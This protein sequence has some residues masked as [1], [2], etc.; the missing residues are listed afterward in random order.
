MS[1]I[2]PK[3]TKSETLAFELTQELIEALGGYTSIRFTPLSASSV[4]LSDN[5]ARALL[6]YLREAR[7]SREA[8]ETVVKPVLRKWA[9]EITVDLRMQSTRSSD[10][11]DLW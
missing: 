6:R 7:E 5:N 2:P 1:K 4:Q 9:E 8:L 10:D 3:E 11:S